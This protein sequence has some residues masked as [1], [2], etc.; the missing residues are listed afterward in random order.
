[1]KSTKKLA[2]VVGSVLSS[3]RA[4]V[5]HFA[6]VQ[7]GLPLCIPIS[8]RPTVKTRGCAFHSF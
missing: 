7:S 3:G 1:M 4:I 5:E 8:P 6:L 2:L